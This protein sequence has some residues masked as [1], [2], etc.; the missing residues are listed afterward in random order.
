MIIINRFRIILY[1]GILL[2][3]AH[4]TVGIIAY[5]KS[6]QSHPPRSI[7]YENGT[8][9]SIDWQTWYMN[10]PVITII[11]PNPGTSAIIAFRPDCTKYN[12]CDADYLFYYLL[13]FYV[14]LTMWLF[15]CCGSAFFGEREGG[16]GDSEKDAWSKLIN[17]LKVGIISNLIFSCKVLESTNTQIVTFIKFQSFSTIFW[18]QKT[19]KYDYPWDSSLHIDSIV[20]NSWFL[21]Y[22]RWKLHYTYQIKIRTITTFWF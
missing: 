19:K 5:M 11:F 22:I 17:T 8:L 3:I 6:N 12:N 15:V 1:G 4:L 21:I 20:S 2:Y 14:D 18:I 10:L 7:R 16:S 9:G 13:L